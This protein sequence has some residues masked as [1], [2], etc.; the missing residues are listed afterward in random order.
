MSP[1]IQPK[2]FIILQDIIDQHQL[3]NIEALQKI[4]TLMES[5]LADYA[6]LLTFK[7]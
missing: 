2:L 6:L 1:E 4:L 7:D 3:P 5:T